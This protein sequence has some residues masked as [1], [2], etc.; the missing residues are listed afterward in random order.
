MFNLDKAIVEWRRRMIAAGIK[1]SDVLD[2]LESHLREEIQN[3]L[4]SGAGPEQAFA[5]AVSRVGKAKQLKTE[6]AKV[7][8]AEKICARENLRRWSVIGA[9]VFVYLTLSGSWYFGVRSGKMEITIVDVVFGMGTVAPIILFGWLGRLLAKS[10][11]VI[12][13]NWILVV[14][15][16]VMF[17]GA[18]LFRIFLPAIAPANLVHLQIAILWALAPSIGFGNCVSA[19]FARCAELR[20]KSA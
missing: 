2:E 3:Q 18:A 14:A 16:G 1:S 17:F 19:W 4:R 7:K 10:L 13:E 15:M 11:P 9:I 5:A 12:N 6:F 20:K 8:A